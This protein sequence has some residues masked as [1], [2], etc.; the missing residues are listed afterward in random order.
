M[1]DGWGKEPDH[2]R[3]GMSAGVSVGIFRPGGCIVSDVEV[4]LDKVLHYASHTGYNASFGHG[5]PEVAD[6]AL[7]RQTL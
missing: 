6:G 3:G 7:R 1:R 2:E 5:A 4:R